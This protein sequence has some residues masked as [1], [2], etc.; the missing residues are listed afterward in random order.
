MCVCVGG[1]GALKKKKVDFSI[2]R[3]FDFT[4]I[5]SFILFFVFMNLPAA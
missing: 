3:G 5:P 1:G 4:I 2:N